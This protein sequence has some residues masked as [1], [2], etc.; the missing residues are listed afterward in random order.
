MN[1]NKQLKIGLASGL[2]LLSATVVRAGDSWAA[3]RPVYQGVETL[4][5][6]V[7]GLVRGHLFS[8][9]LPGNLSRSMSAVPVNSSDRFFAERLEK[10]QARASR[11][12]LEARP[13]APTSSPIA[14]AAWRDMAISEE[15]TAVVD[16]LADTLLQR[17]QLERFGQDSGAYALNPVNWDAEFLASAT[18]L[19]GAYLYV[20]GLSTDWTMGSLRVDLDSPSGMSL[21]ETAESGEGRVAELRLS[22]KGSPLSFNSTWGLRSGSFR[23]ESVGVAYAAHF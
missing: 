14:L 7:Y 11:R 21:R 18:T 22:K 9:L 13:S 1:M 3:A 10:R 2:L 16:A 4:A 20:A 15:K 8:T 19:G 12:I 23:T 17:Y 6:S 5:D